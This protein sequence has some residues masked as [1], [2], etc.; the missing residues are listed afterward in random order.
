M[1]PRS[2]SDDDILAAARVCLFARGPSATIEEIAKRVGVSGPA[3]LKRFG[4]KEKLVM[5]ALVSEAP[6][7][8]SHG[9][10]PG[11]LRPQLLRVLL[12]IERML[13]QAAPAL[14][15]MR[16]GG[17]NVSQ[18]I[19]NA[20]PRLARRH[21]RAWLEQARHSHGLTHPDLETASDL[22]CSLVEA[23]GFLSWIEPTWVDGEDAWAGRA[24]DVVFGG[25]Q[26][27]AV[28]RHSLRAPKV[29]AKRA[30]RRAP[31][32]ARRVYRARPGADK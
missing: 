25:L 17:A 8:L 18:W 16:A 7:D 6:P 21:V 10:E 13:R 12:H 24:V 28:T 26:E 29:A 20:P 4:S 19:V 9:P 5:R 23:R 11:D 1:R 32:T 14:A 22:L 30:P 3:V 2:V 31:R 27:P 15:T